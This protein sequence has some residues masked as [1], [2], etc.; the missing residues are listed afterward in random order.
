MKWKKIKK[1]LSEE[2]RNATE[3]PIHLSNKHVFPQMYGILSI[4]ETSKQLRSC[5]KGSSY[6]RNNICNVYI[7]SQQKKR[8][9][10]VFEQPKCNHCKTT[11]ID[12]MIL[13][14][15]RK[16]KPK[17]FAM[18]E[19]GSFLTVDHILPRSKGGKDTKDN[20]QILCNE[21]NT[22]KGDSL[23]DF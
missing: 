13:K 18:T 1:F 23:D 9:K 22:K 2:G 14:V 3:Y 21:C 10:L 19:N 4:E 15:S 12:F 16:D 5:R 7:G 20:K 11:L 6:I 8:L 17:L